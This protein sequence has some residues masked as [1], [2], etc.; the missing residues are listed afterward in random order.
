[1][2]PNRIDYSLFFQGLQELNPFYTTFALSSLGSH[3]IRSFLSSLLELLSVLV[4]DFLGYVLLCI[5]IRSF[6]CLLFVMHCIPL[7]RLLCGKAFSK[8]CF[9][10]GCI[11]LTCAVDDLC[12][13]CS[14]HWL[15][16][17]SFWLGLCILNGVGYQLSGSVIDDDSCC[18]LGKTSLYL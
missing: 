11:N 5:P 1:M 10:L 2:T 13:R 4:I 14:H 6:C 8:Y 18:N 12:D 16:M 9:G 17:L 15:W 3:Q 7:T